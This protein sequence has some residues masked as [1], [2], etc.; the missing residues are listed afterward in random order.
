MKNFDFV[1]TKLAKDQNIPLTPGKITGACGRLLCCLQYEDQNYI[2]SAKG[3]PNIGEVVKTD[4][5]DGKV[6]SVD[7]LNRKCKVLVN[8]NK[9]EIE[10]KINE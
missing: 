1:S 5:G 8:G 9:E 10:Y 7:V 4:N 2:E 3:L 6:V